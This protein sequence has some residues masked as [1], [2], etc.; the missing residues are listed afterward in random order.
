MATSTGPPYGRIAAGV[1]VRLGADRGH[2]HR[3]RRADH[4]GATATATCSATTR[5]RTGSPPTARPALDH[6]SLIFST[7]GAT[8]AILIV[9]RRHLRRVPRRHPALAA[10]RLRRRRHVRR[11]GRVPDRRRRGQAAPAGRHPASTTH[12]PTS[13]YPSGHEAATCCLYV[14]HRDPGHRPRPRLVAMAVPRSPRSP[15]RS[16]VAVSRMYRGEHH[17]TDILGSLLFAALWLTAAT[18]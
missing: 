18:C 4:Q 10:G 6:W 13:A 7:L 1:V 15:C 12:L 14:A 2:R 9:A 11:T 8:Q 17:P 3:H 5:S 16:L